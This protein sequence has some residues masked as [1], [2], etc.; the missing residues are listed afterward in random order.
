[1]LL[2][3]IG[4]FF[5]EEEQKLFGSVSLA[6]NA[7]PPK[8]FNNPLIDTGDLKSKVAYKTSKDKKVKEG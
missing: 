2:D 8:R 4:K 6:P 3:D 7:V 5:R 1:M